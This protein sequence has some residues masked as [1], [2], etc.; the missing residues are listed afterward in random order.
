MTLATASFSRSLVSRR[1]ACRLIG[2]RWKA[3]STS[4][5]PLMLPLSLL[6]LLFLLLLLPFTI[7]L[8]L[9]VFGQASGIGGSFKQKKKGR[10]TLG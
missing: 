10:R 3:F 9:S 6:L 2:D 8:L 1:L 4:A 7:A 5:S